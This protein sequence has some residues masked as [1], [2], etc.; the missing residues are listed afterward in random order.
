MTINIPQ[1]SS[2]HR[3]GVKKK[4]NTEGK[5]FSFHVF[6]LFLSSNEK[7]IYSISSSVSLVF[8]LFFIRK[9]KLFFCRIFSL[10]SKSLLC[11]YIYIYRF[12]IILYWL[13]IICRSCCVLYWQNNDKIFGLTET[14]A[15]LNGA[16]EHIL[17]VCVCVFV[18][19]NKKLKL[20]KRKKKV[21]RVHVQ[22]TRLYTIYLLIQ[23]DT[24][25]D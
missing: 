10:S 9:T 21:K 25:T 22:A 3:L 12:P 4:K 6:V 19:A 5:D 7:K 23:S 15:H 13:I 24:L 18:R 14:E 17:C 16:P 2:H 8:S 20:C 1:P 11:I